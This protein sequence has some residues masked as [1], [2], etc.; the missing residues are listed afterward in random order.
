VF[1]LCKNIY[2][3]LYR[4]KEFTVSLDFP[5]H[6]TLQEDSKALWGSH[7]Q[8]TIIYCVY[9][10]AGSVYC[11]WYLENTIAYFRI[12]CWI[13]LTQYEG[14]ALRLK[15]YKSLGASLA[16][17]DSAAFLCLCFHSAHSSASYRYVT[18]ML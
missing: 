12:Q 11:W 17:G 3:N 1:F 15:F 2:V 9:I 8:A 16:E 7:D 18:F 6:Y 4:Y 14:I 10:V 13:K 5:T